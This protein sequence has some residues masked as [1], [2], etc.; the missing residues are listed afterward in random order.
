MNKIFLTWAGV[1]MALTSVISGCK[2]QEKPEAPNVIIIYAD[3]LGYSD[4]GIYGGDIPTPHIDAIG[5]NGIRFTSFY[6]AGPVCTPSRFGLLTGAYPIRSQDK[7]TRALM[8]FDTLKLAPSEKTLADYLS[9]S[10]YETALIGKWHLGDVEGSLPTAHGFDNFTGF[11][12][13]CIDYYTHR[14]GPVQENWYVDGKPGKESGYS[15]DLITEHALRFLDKQ[16]GKDSPFLLYLPY[17]APHFGKTDPAGFPG[18]TLLLKEAPFLDFTV[19]NT[20]QAPAEYVEKFAHVSDP[21]RRVYSAMVASLDDNVG[22]V[23]ERVRALGLE[24]NTIIWFI[25][26]NGG[27][28]E[29]YYG[30]ARNGKL[31]GEKGTLWEGGIRVPGLVQWK[32][33]IRPGQ[34]NDAPVGNIDLLPT[35]AGWLDFD[36]DEDGVAW[37]GIDISSVLLDG[38]KP[39]RELFWEFRGETAY[40][41]GDWKLKGDSALYNLSEDRSETRN[42]AADH[43]DK[44]RELSDKRNRIIHSVSDQQNHLNCSLPTRLL[45]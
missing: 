12:L 35:L 43:P 39:E 5:H 19:A 14:Y 28:A 26:D 37:D 21:Y 29:S 27:Y 8:P 18:N 6:V 36:R 44:V 33:K 25:S 42:L 24:E 38:K 7:L 3:D 30:H 10:G 20:L 16:S 41:N 2:K 1:V 9:R 23:L 4:L 22:K 34:V 32:G 40:R 17:N 31:R 13:G 11:T 45:R 15:T